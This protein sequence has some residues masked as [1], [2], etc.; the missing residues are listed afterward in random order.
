MSVVRYIHWSDPKRSVPQSL[1]GFKT[2]INS[3]RFLL[4][5]SYIPI[6]YSGDKVLV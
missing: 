2:E 3:L 1:K 6:K 4:C 5:V